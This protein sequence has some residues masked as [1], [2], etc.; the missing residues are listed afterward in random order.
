V[1]LKNEERKHG[2]YRTARLALAAYD[3]LAPAMAG[4]GSRVG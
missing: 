4:V 3:A 1:L 2:E